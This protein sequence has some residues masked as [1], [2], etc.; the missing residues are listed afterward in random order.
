MRTA[1]LA[2]ILLATGCTQRNATAP[3][4]AWFTEIAAQSG[5]GFHHDAARKGEFHMPEIMGAGCGLVDTDN[6]GDLDVILVQSGGGP[7]ELFRNE[8]I[9][10]GTLRFTML[11]GAL[12]G[13]SGYGMGVA[14]GDFDG[15]GLTDLFIS[16]FGSD[17]LLRNLGGNR[18]AD[19][20]ARAGV[21]DARWSTS[22]AFFDYDR[23]GRL[24]LFVLHYVDFTYRNHVRC[25]TPAG[26]PDYCTPRA[27]RPVA[28]ALYRNE[29]DGR[30]RD[31]SIAAGITSAL[32]PGLGVTVIDTNDDSW[33][34]LFVAN[35]S[36]ANLLWIN[37]GDGTF[38]EEGLLSGT[39]L[40]ED[41]IAKAGMGVAAADY[42]SDGDED[43]LVLNLKQEGASLFRRDRPGQFID[44]SLATGIRTATYPF[45]GFGTGWFDFDH[46]GRLDLFAANGGVVR[47]GPNLDSFRQR[48]QILP[49]GEGASFADHSTR[50]GPA[51][52]LEEVSRGAA[53]GD[54]DNDGDIDILVSNNDGPA[55]LL[56][57]ER[58][59]AG[60]WLLVDVQPANG[61]VLRLN[62]S[63]GPPL[64]RRARADG[65]YLSASDP[66]VHFG[67]G[68]ATG[69]ESIGITWPDGTVQQLPGG[70]ADRIV[71]VRQGS[72]R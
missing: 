58:G 21:G 9:P 39:A 6:D 14:T 66:R 2:V 31:V 1:A 16:Q 27:Y 50:A 60:H 40:S 25:S 52:Q 34:D 51:L 43:L 8:L 57:N 48:N 41:G 53:F 65:S 63:G 70:A 68:N 32:G 23:D 20:A 33:P 7:H 3:P 10:S 56:R 26:L 36:M 24:D 15:D 29:G 67:L 42:D 5:I 35:D 47:D 38:R 22:S 64:V 71:R 19:V 49:G 46:D 62:R 28:A 30:F 61:A 45:T 18:F 69:H 55:R 4:G 37:N 17:L 54:V 11:D 72:A 59:G 13:V 12:G 44:A